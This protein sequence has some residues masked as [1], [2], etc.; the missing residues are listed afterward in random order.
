MV[1]RGKG[2]HADK[3]WQPPGFLSTFHGIRSKP[4][5]RL[6]LDHCSRHVQR[7]DDSLAGDNYCVIDYTSAV[8]RFINP[9]PDHHH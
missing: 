9:I 5:L 6:F 2:N 7:K 3:Y 4:D 8:Q 1:V